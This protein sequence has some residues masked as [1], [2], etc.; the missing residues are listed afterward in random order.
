[1]LGKRKAVA[2]LPIDRKMVK[3]AKKEGHQHKID[4]MRNLLR[5]EEVSMRKVRYTKAMSSAKEYLKKYLKETSKKGEYICTCGHLF[6]PS[7]YSESHVL[8]HINGST[9]TEY[10]VLS[11]K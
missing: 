6:Y 1:M 11:W 8:A 3:K 9:Y 10:C 4:E 7:T 2:T 5:Q